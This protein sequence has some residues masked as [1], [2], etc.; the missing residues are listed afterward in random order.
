MN[1]I[2]ARLYGLGAICTAS[3]IAGSYPTWHYPWIWGKSI[4]YGAVWPYTFINM[5]RFGEDSICYNLSEDSHPYAIIYK[6]FLRTGDIRTCADK[7]CSSV[8][9]RN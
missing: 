6:E 5:Y 4:L 2:Y 1:T 8:N 7:M 3:Y 9:K